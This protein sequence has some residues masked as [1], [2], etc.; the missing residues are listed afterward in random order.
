MNS[1][2]GQRPKGATYTERDQPMRLLIH[3]EGQTEES[4]VNGVLASYL[5]DRGYSSVSARIVGNA[6]QRARRGG[7]RP[8]PTVRKGIGSHLKADPRCAATTMVDYYGLPSDGPGAWPGRQ[9]ASRLALETRA[10]HVERACTDDLKKHFGADLGRRLVL[11]VM[12]HEF[13]ALLFSDCRR[14]AEGI[15]QPKALKELQ[16]IRDMFSTPEEI[17]DSPTGAPSKRVQRVIPGYDKPFMGVLASLEIE[18]ET[19]REACPHFANWLERL[20]R[21]AASAPP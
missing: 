20:T 9:E 4:F 1:A 21:L 12:I 19:M 13:E 16:Q 10:E 6:R 3:V 7:I 11:F 8:W 17:D 18:I 2:E 15:G 5:T 14:F